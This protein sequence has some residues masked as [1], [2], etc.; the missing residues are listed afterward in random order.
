MVH[1]LEQVN[2]AKSLIQL[3][4]P[5]QY[6][7]ELHYYQ[8]IQ[9]YLTFYNMC[10]LA[11]SWLK[12]T[13]FFMLIFRSLV[14][15]RAFRLY[16]RS[17]VW[18]VSSSPSVLASS[19]SACRW[20]ICQSSFSRPESSVSFFPSG[21]P[22]RWLASRSSTVPTVISSTYWAGLLNSLVISTFELTFSLQTVIVID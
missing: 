8:K 6:W 2:S 4:E 13:N 10:L 9:I 3:I 1:C 12:C 11:I 5:I 22:L 7:W 17:N 14:F 19:A 20:C 16:Q 18:L 15:L 21:R